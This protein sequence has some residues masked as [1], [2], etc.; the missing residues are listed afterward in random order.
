M[1]ISFINDHFKRIWL[2]HKDEF[3]ERLNKLGESGQWILGSE[4]QEFEKSFAGFVGT[5][6]CVAVS[7]GTAAIMLALRALGIR[8]G[9]EVITSSHTFKATISAILDVGAKPVIIDIGND[10]LIDPA[11]I[12]KVITPKTKAIIPVHLAGATC[13][14]EKLEKIAEKYD[15]MVI[16]DS[17]QTIQPR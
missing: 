3:L 11:E 2:K 1:K 10:G 4:I 13:D 12:E 14:M 17:C 5:R 9:D 7:S 8:E 16:E 15:I 6:F